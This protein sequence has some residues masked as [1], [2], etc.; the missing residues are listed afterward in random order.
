MS[1]YTFVLHLEEFGSHILQTAYIDSFKIDALDVPADAKIDDFD[2]PI[3]KE[4]VCRFEV[5]VHYLH[6]LLVQIFDRIYHLFN[7][8]FG[9]S[10]I[11]TSCLFEVSSQIRART[12][13]HDQTNLISL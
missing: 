6:F 7:D 3:V 10:L 1:A 4:H 9:L 13:L 2:H 8:N 12:I 5:E 11:E